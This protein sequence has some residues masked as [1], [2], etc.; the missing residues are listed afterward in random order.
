MGTGSWREI[1]EKV[2]APGKFMPEFEWDFLQNRTSLFVV[3]DSS[4]VD[5]TFT[6]INQMANLNGYNIQKTLITPNHEEFSGWSLVELK[7]QD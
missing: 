5:S 4:Y 2:K 1:S 3:G 6:Q 7:I